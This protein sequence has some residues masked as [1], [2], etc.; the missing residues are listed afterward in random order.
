[1]LQSQNFFDKMAKLWYGQSIAG[2]GLTIPVTLF[3][4]NYQRKFAY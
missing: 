3:S 2:C 4:A 1:M